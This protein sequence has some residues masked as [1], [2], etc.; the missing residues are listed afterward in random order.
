MDKGKLKYTE[1]ELIDLGWDQIKNQLPKR[2]K[3]R[4]FWLWIPVAASLLLGGLFVL[5]N[6]KPNSVAHERIDEQNIAT[7]K[8]GQTD[9][10][11]VGVTEVVEDQRVDAISPPKNDEQQQKERYIP[12]PTIQQSKSSLET[13]RIYDSQT[14]ISQNEYDAQLYPKQTNLDSQNK[15]RRTEVRPKNEDV[16]PVKQS[17]IQKNE[18]DHDIF[19]QPNNGETQIAK[20]GGQVDAYEIEEM[21]AQDIMEEPPQEEIITQ[22]QSKKKLLPYATTQLQS[23]SFDHFGPSVGIGAEVQLNEKRAI[24]F[25]LTGS[26]MK[27]DIN[28]FT[29]LEP[30]DASSLPSIF[31]HFS[32]HMPNNYDLVLIELPVT[33]KQKISERVDLQA[34]FVPS[35]AN[36]SD[37]SSRTSSERFIV[38]DQSIDAFSLASNITNTT[39]SN[40]NLFQISDSF[41]NQFD[42][43]SIGFNL[44]GEASLTPDWSVLV[45][46]NFGY[47]NQ[48]DTQFLDFSPTLIQIGTKLYIQKRKE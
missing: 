26:Y 37:F 28:D 35:Y 25:A 20:V 32:E 39:S 7:E 22:L 19:E 8:S 36:F 31:I 29:T 45:N 41:V 33:L 23:D 5:Q 2:R 1:E 12:R 40:S 10:K 9:R 14:S 46:S 43:F 11:V 48:V 17:V 42:Q 21:V 6:K 24:S 4:I 47:Q 3:D 44:G 18:A 27:Q 38:Q 34:G 13:N 15:L 16:K 30:Y